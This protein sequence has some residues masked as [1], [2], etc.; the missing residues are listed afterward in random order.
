[1]SP[2]LQLLMTLILLFSFLMLMQSRILNLVKLLI[3][4][5]LLLTVYLFLNTYFS[6]SLELLFSSSLNLVIKVIILPWLLWKLARALET[7]GKTDPLTHKSTL[8]FTGLAMVLFAIVVSQPIHSL[9]G[10]TQLFPFSISLANV[11]LAIL[12]II[13]RRRAIS[14][15]IGLLVLENSLFLFALSTTNGLP[16]IIELGISFDLLIGFMIFAVFLV[17][18]RSTHGSLATQD[19]AGLKEVK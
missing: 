9:L 10:L 2:L 1:M 11:F 15:L 3:L 5:N 16:W 7:S 4:Q 6:G 17:R 12:L 18:I 14:Q 13:F 19:L 8:L